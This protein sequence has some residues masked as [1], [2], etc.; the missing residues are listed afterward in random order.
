MRSM[1]RNKLNRKLCHI[2]NRKLCLAYSI[3]AL[4]AAHAANIRGDFNTWIG[5]YAGYNA[6]SGSTG[7]NSL[8]GYG[9]GDRAQGLDDCTFIGAVSAALSQNLSLCTGIGNGTFLHATNDNNCIAIGFGALMG[10]SNMYNV[11]AIGDN[12]LKARGDLSHVTYINGQFY[13]SAQDDEFW[14]S[15]GNGLPV[16]HYYN[17]QLTFPSG[18]AQIETLATNAI[19][20]V[21]ADRAGTAT[22][23]TWANFSMRLSDTASGG[24]TADTLAAELDRLNTMI[25]NLAARV[26]ALEAA[27]N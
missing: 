25:T 20:A 23:A 5:Y 9:A 2:L 8:M 3:A 15:T 6:T 13:A 4:G 14:I 26:T 17:G 18:A 16:M 19:H 27:A 22:S 24:Y 12:A 11:V 21:E 7:C 1:N 10:T